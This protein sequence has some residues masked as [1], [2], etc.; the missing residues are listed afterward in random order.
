MKKDFNEET[1]K[2]IRELEE[3]EDKFKTNPVAKKI[4]MSSTP[5]MELHGDSKGTSDEWELPDSEDSEEQVRKSLKRRTYPCDMADAMAYSFVGRK[6]TKSEVKINYWKYACIF[7]LLGIVSAMIL[8]TP[9][10]VK[11]AEVCTN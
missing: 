6:D 10:F 1:K 4:K 9:L 8:S 2:K 7:I 3:K 11:L 5:T